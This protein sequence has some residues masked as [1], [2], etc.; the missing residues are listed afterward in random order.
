MSD[1]IDMTETTRM[2]MIGDLRKV[3]MRLYYPLEVMLVCAR[4]YAAY[5]L[6]FGKTPSPRHLEE[7]MQVRG[8]FVNHSTVHR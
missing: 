8:V 5:P 1:N 4:W 6:S 2:T 3:L 7:M